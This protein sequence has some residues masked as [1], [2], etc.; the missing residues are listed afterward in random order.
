MRRIL[1]LLAIGMASGA[2][3]LAQDDHPGTNL[4]HG[5]GSYYHQP[6]YRY[7]AKKL[8][9][10]RVHVG[11]KKLHRL[12]AMRH[13]APTDKAQRQMR[14]FTIR[15]LNERQEWLAWRYCSNSNPTACA[16]AAAARFGI[17]S[18]WLIACARSEGGLGP[19]DYDTMN[20]QGSGAGG[21][22]QF[23]SGT[24]YGNA[25]ASGLPKPWT[26]LDSHDQ[27]WVAAYMFSIGQSG[28]WTGAGC[29]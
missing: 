5:C 23:M 9:R 21:N 25:G 15:L 12:A 14:R 26:W 4:R 22:W 2:P 16:K 24:F 1:I 27:A 28:Q 19:S 8:I 18:G 11:P 3:A 7:V 29:N 10:E 17:S 20:S 13:C 6:Y